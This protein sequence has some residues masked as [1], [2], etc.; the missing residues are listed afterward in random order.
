MA[1][2]IFRVHA[3]R[4]MFQRRITLDDV[5]IVLALGEVIEAR[6]DDLPYPSRLLL[7]YAGGR[8]L[9]I[10]VADNSATDEMIV[11]TIYE[12]DPAQWLP[13]F[14]RRRDS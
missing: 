12:P 7:G 4:R 9:H 2:L 11:A 8:A 14:K 6:P 3:L 5:R 13:G 1:K 10:V